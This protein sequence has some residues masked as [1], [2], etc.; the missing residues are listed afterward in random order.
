[1]RRPKSS[2]KLAGLRQSVRE[3]ANLICCNIQKWR[4]GYQTYLYIFGD[5]TFIGDRAQGYSQW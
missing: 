4:Q 2:T 5:H 3:L 1:M